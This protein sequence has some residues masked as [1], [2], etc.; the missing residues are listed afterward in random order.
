MTLNA[1][2]A[3]EQSPRHTATVKVIDKALPSVVVV[4]NILWVKEKRE[5]SVSLGSGTIVHASGYI[6]TN[7]HVAANVGRTTV[8][9][10]DGSERR[11]RIVARL[12]HEDLGLLKIDSD[13]PLQPLPL[14]RSDDLMLGEPVVIIGSPQGLTYSVSTGIIS[15][16]NRSRTTADAYLP[17]TVQV[18]A[19]V[20]KGN[21][22]G[23]LINA[24]AQQIGIVTYKLD[25]ENL[26]FAIAIDRVRSVFPQMLAAEQR[27]AFTLDL[28]VDMLGNAAEVISV[29]E[30][31]PAAKAGIRVDD[32]I[33]GIGD[34]TIRHGLDFWLAVVDRQAGD[35]LTFRLRRGYEDVDVK[36]VL[37]PLE[38][39]QPI[40]KKGMTGGLDYA[41]YQGKWS[42][43]PD[44]D[45]L[46]PVETGRT[47]KPSADT[48][49]AGREWF[50]L[51]FSGFLEVPTDGLYTFYCNSDD[52]SRLYIGNRLVV[53]NDAGH[54]ARE[55][56]AHVRLKAG[57]HLFTLTYFN[58]VRN[59]ALKV[60]VEGPDLVKQEIPAS[61][62][63]VRDS[64]EKENNSTPSDALP[65][66]KAV[67]SRPVDAG[68]TQA[69]HNE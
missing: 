40:P 32:L 36:V 8:V 17:W 24:L 41:A 67:G 50:G 33:T 54:P 12:P 62:F 14:G 29:A 66:D 20:N 61:W 43:L 64:K 52:G 4:R 46:S 3:D 10:N 25:A 37:G 49:K 26:G 16:L 30:E 5:Y 31:S 63:F 18:S 45:T 65:E 55:A 51:R 22:G 27:F 57:L 28:E 39:D 6:L 2:V 13:Q 23:P 42:R 15:G 53:D 47:E 35:Q 7:D 68:E 48:Y 9:L 19:A 59:K 11:Y 38:L 21:S 34:F 60:S 58:G 1:A 44:F 56:G 69:V